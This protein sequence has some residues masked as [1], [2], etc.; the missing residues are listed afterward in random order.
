MLE[1]KKQFAVKG[2]QLRAVRDGCD[3]SKK[4]DGFYIGGQMHGEVLMTRAHLD[5]C[6]EYLQRDSFTFHEEEKQ[7][8]LQENLVK[9]SHKS[10]AHK[11]DVSIFQKVGKNITRLNIEINREHSHHDVFNFT[12]FFKEHYE[13]A[14]VINQYAFLDKKSDIYRIEMLERIFNVFRL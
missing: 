14:M 6:I 3:F 10:P 9:I 5:E 4:K 1:I 12:D 11:M 2:I 8:F 7:K 13:N